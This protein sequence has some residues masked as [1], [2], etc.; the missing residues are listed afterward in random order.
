MVDVITTMHL[1]FYVP[2]HISY[3]CIRKMAHRFCTYVMSTHRFKVEK[4][5]PPRDGESNTNDKTL[6]DVV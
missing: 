2:P 4:N 1:M 5:N 3:Q 6:L